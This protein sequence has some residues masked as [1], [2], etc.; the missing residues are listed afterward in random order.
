MLTLFLTDEAVSAL[1][2]IKSAI[3]IQIVR[4]LPKMCYADKLQQQ[5]DGSITQCM[6]CNFLCVIQNA[7][8]IS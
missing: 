1:R 2:Y 8:Q 5:N 3:I 4:Y 7:A 6:Q